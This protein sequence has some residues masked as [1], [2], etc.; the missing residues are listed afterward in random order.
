MFPEI[1]VHLLVPFL[2]RFQVFEFFLQLPRRILVP[3]RDRA[4]AQYHL[5]P[6]Q[7]LLLFR[8]FLVCLVQRRHFPLVL[9][10]VILCRSRDEPGRIPPFDLVDLVRRFRQPPRITLRDPHG[11]LPI[12]F[13]Q[14]I[15][16][17]VSLKKFVDLLV[18][19]RHFRAVSRRCTAF[20][21]I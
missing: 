5:D 3:R 19:R 6:L 13:R 1:G 4:V 2:L 20:L 15:V 9:A 16:I 14:G 8:S 7:V 21:V 18:E 10:R 11:A 12:R 17:F